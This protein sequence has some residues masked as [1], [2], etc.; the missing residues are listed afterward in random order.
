M[1]NWKKIILK[2]DN[3]ELATVTASVGLRITGTIPTGGSGDNVMVVTPQGHVK[4]ISQGSVSGVDTTYTSSGA[5][6]TMSSAQS[7]GNVAASTTFSIVP[8]QL[9]HNSLLN[10]EDNEHIAWATASSGNVIHSTNYTNTVYSNGTGIDFSDPDAA[11]NYTASTNPNQ[12]HVTGVGALSAGSIVSGF[13]NIVTTGNISGSSIDAQN[14]SAV[15]LDTNQITASNLNVTGIFVAEEVNITGSLAVSGSFI[16]NAET[17]AQIVA[18]TTTGSNSFGSLDTDS[19]YFTGSVTASGGIS[20]SFF[21][22]DGS[23]LTGIDNSDVNTATLTIGNGLV[24]NSSNTTF[25]GTSNETLKGEAVSDGGLEVVSGGFRIKTD[26]IKTANILNGNVTAVKIADQAITKN[27]LDNNIIEAHSVIGPLSAT[28]EILIS[29][30]SGLLAK[31]TLGAISSYVDSEISYTTAT[32]SVTSVTAD[33]SVDGI[34]LTQTSNAT[35]TPVIT[36]GGSA[37]INNTHWITGGE[38]LSIANGGTG[39]STQILAADALLN[40]SQ[41]GGLTIGNS[42]DTITIPGNLEILGD[43]TSL[44]TTN[45]TITDKFMLIGSG[46]TNTDHDI[47]IKFGQ[48]TT[49][50]NTLIWDGNYSGSDGRFGVKYNLAETGNNSVADPNN[51]LSAMSAS[52]HLVGF[53]EGNNPEDVK[54][55][56]VGN[57]KLDG[58]AFYIYA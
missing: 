52:Y 12:S 45:T 28:H 40:V 33:S 9:D 26:G 10:H 23:G 50:G 36:L 41:G 46:S 43:L 51:D 19:H 7:P 24:L 25:N 17:F 38:D 15:T 55:D 11:G 57:I 14:V 27:K 37:E 34:T 2:D 16:H 4:S 20:A 3:A 32:G 47:G 18:N 8:A 31:T 13:G 56:H 21:T 42:G 39:Q 44:S 1:A 5:N 49:Q 6:I 22:G 58:G 54:A 30:G 29:T 48:A 35:T 53:Y